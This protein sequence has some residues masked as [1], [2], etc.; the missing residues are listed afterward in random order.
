LKNRG[1]KDSADGAATIPPSLFGPVGSIDDGLA[2]PGLGSSRES[3]LVWALRERDSKRLQGGK[4][5]L[6]PSCRHLNSITQ[7]DLSSLIAVLASAIARCVRERGGC[8]RR[9]S[10]SSTLR[11]LLAHL[12][13][14]CSVSVS[15]SVV[16]AAGWTRLV[17][18][19]VKRNLIV[20]SVPPPLPSRFDSNC[21]PVCV[22]AEV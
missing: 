2:P 10:P 1:A 19:K 7:P 6:M 14:R 16:R 12:S 4:K 9:P 5:R 13:L 18:P 22:E 21:R 11:C 8:K 15:V 17:Q 3:L 20:Q